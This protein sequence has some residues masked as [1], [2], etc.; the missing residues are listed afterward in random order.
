MVFR[1]FLGTT[2]FS[3]GPPPVGN[4]DLLGLALFEPW[5]LRE[6][7]AKN[8]FFGQKRPK[9]VF[10]SKSTKTSFLVKIDQNQSVRSKSTKT[11]L[12]G[13]NRPKPVCSA[14]I[15]RPKPVFFRSKGAENH[16]G[17]PGNILPQKTH[18]VTPTYIV[19]QNSSPSARSQYPVLIR[20]GPLVCLSVC[21][22]VQRRGLRGL[23]ASS[24]PNHNPKRPE[25]HLACNFS[26]AMWQANIPHPKR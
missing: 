25:I 13:Q 23:G 10:R 24:R 12:F 9:P 15:D 26:P 7:P 21:L 18:I 2:F 1:N 14:K 17:Y 19:I 20:D 4:G 22:S 11:S 6:I 5:A 8:H 16:A 3:V